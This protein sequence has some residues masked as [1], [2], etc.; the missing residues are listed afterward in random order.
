MDQGDTGGETVTS[1]AELRQMRARFE[2]RAAERDALL[3]RRLR[4]ARADFERCIRRSPTRSGFAAESSV[5]T[6]A[7][8]DYDWARLDYLCDV[9]R[10][11][12]PLVRRDLDRFRGFLQRT[13]EC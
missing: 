8:M 11:V 13:L 5:A 12:M 3:A 7:E 1:Q 2:R 10:R 9:Y 4:Q 6:E